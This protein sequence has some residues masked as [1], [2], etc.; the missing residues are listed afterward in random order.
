MEGRNKEWIWTELLMMDPLS[1]LMTSLF[2]QQRKTPATAMKKLSTSPA[3][4]SVSNRVTWFDV[5]LHT[6]VSH[7]SMYYYTPT[8]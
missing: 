6:N 3:T 1:T 2:V 5:L 8:Y 4:F 7:G